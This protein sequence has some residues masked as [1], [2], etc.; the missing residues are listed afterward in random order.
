MFSSYHRVVLVQR[1]ICWNLFCLFVSCL[2]YNLQHKYRYIEMCSLFVV[3][4]RYEAQW[5]IGSLTTV[6]C[7]D[8]FYTKHYIGESYCRLASVDTF[9]QQHQASLQERLIIFMLQ[10]QNGIKLSYDKSIPI[11]SI[12]HWQS[13]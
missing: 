3:E 8:V 1:L 9:H 6:A 2:L 12:T 4:I 10:K 11:L 7:S 13:L 5:D